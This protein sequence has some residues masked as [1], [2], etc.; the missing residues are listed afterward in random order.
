MEVRK[1]NN[2]VEEYNVEKLET[3]ISESFKA[4]NEEVQSA[5]IS[6][7]INNLYVYDN[8]STSEIRR[9]VEDCLMSINKKA[10]KQYISKYDAD[11]DLRKKQDFI[12]QY[13]VASNAATG[14]QFDSNANVTNKNIVTLGQENFNYLFTF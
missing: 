3:S 6:T 2:T 9:Q 11:K 10:A 8:I 5:V 13:I 4:A 1:S 12:R 7:I 14:S